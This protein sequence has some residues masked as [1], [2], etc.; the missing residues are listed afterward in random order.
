M[1]RYNLSVV[2][3]LFLV[4]TMLACGAKKSALGEN[5]SEGRRLFVMSCQNCHLLPNPSS[6]S[7]E[8][9]PAIVKRYGARSKLTD[10]EI[11]SITTFLI[12]N[13]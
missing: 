13:N 2:I 5:R 8:E 9:W 11:A 6:Q 7:D 12:A 4:G 3:V 1:S 10:S